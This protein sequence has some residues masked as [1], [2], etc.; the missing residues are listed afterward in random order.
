LQTIDDVA[1]GA[2]RTKIRDILASFLF[3]G[4][5]VDKKVSV[6]SGGERARL[7]LA[8][9]LLEPANLLVLDEP[10][11]HLDM[12]SKD[13]LKNALIKYD[14]TVILVSHDRDFLTGIVDTV[15]EFKNK[16]MQQH[17]GGISDFLRKKKLETLNQL[18]KIK[19]QT[20]SKPKNKTGSKLKYEERKELDKKIRKAI[21]LVDDSE[22]RILKIES[23][24][25]EMDKL[26]SNPE[27]IDD[28]SVFETYDQLKKKLEAEMH[29]WEK[30]SHKCDAIKA[31]K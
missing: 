11:N 28:I 26:L 27:N 10:T 14:G 13:I 16:K 29:K 12:R 19:K 9:L 23:E 3:R 22:N 21:R 7:S 4:E 17:L 25:E 30:L 18:N 15:Y 31:L 6:L 2:I 24:I 1:V 20:I 8:K 5:D